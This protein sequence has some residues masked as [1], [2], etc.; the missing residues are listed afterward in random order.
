[1]YLRGFLTQIAR[2]LRVDRTRLA[3]GY[4]AFVHRFRS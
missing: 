2:A 4:V 1:V 3:E